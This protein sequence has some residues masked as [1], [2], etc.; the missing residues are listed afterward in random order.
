[1]SEPV[2]VN[3]PGFSLRVVVAIIIAILGVL[4]LLGTLD[5]M[6]VALGVIAILTAV[7]LVT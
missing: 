1:M 6:D 4:V 7:G 2:R 5:K 3:F